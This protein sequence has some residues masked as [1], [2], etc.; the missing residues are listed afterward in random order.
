MTQTTP[1]AKKRPRWRDPR[2]W[3]GILITVACIWLAL[4]DVSFSEVASHMSKAN[5]LLLFALSAPAHFIA[6]WVRAL[7][8]RHLIEAIE[9]VDRM[10]VFRA[11][12]VGFMANNIFPLRVGEVIRAWY[13]ARETQASGTALLGTVIVE[14]IIDAAAVASLGIVVLGGRGIRLEG[15]EFLAFATPLLGGLAALL[16]FFSFLGRS[17]DRAIRLATAL[18]PPFVT[19]A[20]RDRIEGGLRHISA[21]LGSLRGGAHLF[22]IAAHTAVIWL[23]LTVIPFLVGFHALGIE[24][25]SPE[26][27]L[28]AGFVTLVAVGVAVAFP[29][30]PGFFGPYHLACQAALASFGVAR[31]PAFAT[32]TLVHFTFWI[33]VTALGLGVLWFRRTSFGEIEEAAERGKDPL[34]SRR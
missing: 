8:W 3:I 21:G 13:L 32:G 4:R 31:A 28:A 25:D 20:V 19:P 24:F 33:C 15:V 18:L 17:P 2:I 22:W 27:T 29:S 9:P 16:V 26:T 11:T 10:P 6:I 5:L 7:R 30:A 12:A 1:E 34:S 14:R 23:I